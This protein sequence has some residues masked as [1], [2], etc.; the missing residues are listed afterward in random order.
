MKPMLSEFAGQ[1]SR[2][3]QKSRITKNSI[4]QKKTKSRISKKSLKKVVK[5]IDFISQTWSEFFC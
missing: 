5:E 3:F 4:K 2:K 1:F